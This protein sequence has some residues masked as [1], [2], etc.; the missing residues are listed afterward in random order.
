[1]RMNSSR[2]LRVVLAV[3]SGSNVDP[4]WWPKHPEMVVPSRP[5][6]PS[7]QRNTSEAMQDEEPGGVF[8]YIS[9]PLAFDTLLRYGTY[10]V[11]SISLVSKST[12]IVF[13]SLQRSRDKQ[14]YTRSNGR[15]NAQWPCFGG[16]RRL[17][18][19]EAVC[20]KAG[21]ASNE[22]ATT[23]NSQLPHFVMKTR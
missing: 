21:D 23:F 10:L 6:E 17:L 13:G 18:V 9:T 22:G 1:M 12:S 8:L 2:A 3:K 7:S 5:S 20:G 16:G 14:I 11:K 15:S 4:P 19:A